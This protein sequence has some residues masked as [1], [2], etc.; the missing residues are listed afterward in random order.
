MMECGYSTRK[1]IKH[2][3]DVKAKCIQRRKK[4]QCHNKRQKDR[5]LAIKM[6]L[7]S[8]LKIATIN[9]SVYA[10]YQLMMKLLALTFNKS[11]RYAVSIFFLP[12][13]IL[14]AFEAF[15]EIGVDGLFSWISNAQNWIGGIKRVFSQI[16]TA[17][18][19]LQSAKK[20]AKGTFERQHK[21]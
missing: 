7:N 5:R 21:R 6:H 8:M 4:K 1:S 20:R 3:E 10:D 19:V 16:N 14:A 2:I 12:P 13:D 11:F 17:D 18:Q 15:G 9:T